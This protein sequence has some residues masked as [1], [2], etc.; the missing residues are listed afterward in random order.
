MCL[1]YTYT[2]CMNMCRWPCN[3]VLVAMT[4]L[5]IVLFWPVMVGTVCSY[6]LVPVIVVKYVLLHVY[7]HEKWVVSGVVML[8]TVRLVY[9][10]D[11]YI[12]HVYM[13][14]KC[15]REYGCTVWLYCM[16]VLYGCV[17]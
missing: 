12:V 6:V 4:M 1:C 7:T 14:D 10:S 5:T 17:I 8:C 11:L 13:A 15:H 2:V 9:H 16:V 3:N